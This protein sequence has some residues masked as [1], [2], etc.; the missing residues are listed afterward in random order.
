MCSYE[1]L[2]I[3]RRSQKSKHI[4]SNW[5]QANQASHQAWLLLANDST[6]I[7]YL[8]SSFDKRLVAMAAVTKAIARC[9]L[10]AAKAGAAK[11]AFL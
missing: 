5:L 11:A 10:N 3:I 6:A 8:V 2:N 9:R 7:T 1:V 4:T